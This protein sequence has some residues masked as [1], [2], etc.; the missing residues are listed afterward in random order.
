[1]KTRRLIPLLLALALILSACSAL[2]ARLPGGTERIARQLVRAGNIKNL[3]SVPGT[4]AQE[5][6]GCESD[7]EILNKLYG[8]RP[9]HCDAYCLYLP[10]YALDACE[11]AIFSFS[12]DYQLDRIKLAVSR[13]LA[14]QMEAYREHDALYRMLADA[15]YGESGG[16][17]YLIIA[18]SKSADAA[19]KKMLEY[20]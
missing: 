2:D 5:I 11:V 10:K 17:Y 6:Y 4:Q 13:R 8:L 1:M 19:E 12:N 3:C 18:P 7:A 15:R 16:Y 20:N 14:S 9:Q